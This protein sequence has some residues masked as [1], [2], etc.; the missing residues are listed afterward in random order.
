MPYNCRSCVNPLRLDRGSSRCIKCCQ[1]TEDLDCCHCDAKRHTRPVN[2]LTVNYD[3]NLKMKK[4]V[5]KF[6]IVKFIK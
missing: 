3:G 4:S 5:L 2:P 6:K 1:S